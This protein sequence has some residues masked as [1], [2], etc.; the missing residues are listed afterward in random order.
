MLA[1]SELWVPTF[2]F[3]GRAPSP[4]KPGAPKQPSV[5]P[6]YV[7]QARCMYDL[8][9]RT[10]APVEKAKGPESFPYA[11]PGAWSARLPQPRRFGRQGRAAPAVRASRLQLPAALESK[12][13]SDLWVQ[14]T[15]VSKWGLFVGVLITRALLLGVC[16][17]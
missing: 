10:G 13:P 7:L 3:E 9:T 1:G 14:V 2:V 4:K 12:G 5:D 17:L 8:E 6:A 15:C 16:P 11:G